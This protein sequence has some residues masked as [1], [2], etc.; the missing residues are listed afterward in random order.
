MFKIAFR[1]RCALPVRLWDEFD[2]T[3][4]VIRGAA[5][6]IWGADAGDR[7]VAIV[8]HLWVVRCHQTGR[9]DLSETVLTRVDK[10]ADQARAQNERDPTCRGKQANAAVPA[11]AGEMMERGLI[12]L[13]PGMGWASKSPDPPAQDLRARLPSSSPGP[14]SPLEQ[15]RASG[16]DMTGET[17]LTRLIIGARPVLDPETY[18]FITTERGAEV[19]DPA[20]IGWFREA[21]GLTLIAT[22]AWAERAGLA[23]VYPCRRITLSVH[24][25][26]DAVGL[27]AAVSGALAEAGISCNPVA[28]FH[29]DHLFVPE[30]DAR[31]AM[32]VLKRL[33]ANASDRRA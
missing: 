12:P 3:A 21:E 7:L 9:F 28:S 19:D 30:A 26:L 24:S 20:V 16:G 1:M 8:M 31:E 10:L 5:R 18:V 2:R 15:M 23:F 25:A 27:M 11:F 33:S 32:G 13:P 4:S 14:I 22:R 29:H 6:E 17:D